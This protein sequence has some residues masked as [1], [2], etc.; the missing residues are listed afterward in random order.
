MLVLTKLK[1][2]QIKAVTKTVENEVFQRV[3]GCCEPI[4]LIFKTYPFRAEELNLSVSFFRE[5]CVSATGLIDLKEAGYTCN[6][7]G[8]ADIVIRLK[9]KRLF[10][11]GAFF[12]CV[13]LIA[14]NL[15]G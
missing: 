5:C 11:F 8:T 13:F 4:V 15:K 14:S 2:S 9:V 1:I 3:G 7:S 10:H 12:I 6:L